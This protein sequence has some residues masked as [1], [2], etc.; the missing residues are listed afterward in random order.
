MDLLEMD[1]FEIVH[2][3]IGV[4]SQDEDLGIMFGQNGSFKNSL[5]EGSPTDENT[6]KRAVMREEVENMDVI[7]AEGNKAHLVAVDHVVKENN[8]DLLSGAATEPVKDREEISVST[9]PPNASRRGKKNA[10]SKAEKNSNSAICAKPMR[11]K[12]EKKP[13]SKKNQVN[14][15]TAAP[16]PIL[17]NDTSSST[18]SKQPRKE[19]ASE[20][21]GKKSVSLK[22]NSHVEKAA[23]PT[24]ANRASRAPPKNAPHGKVKEKRN[25]LRA[26][27]G[28]MDGNNAEVKKARVGKIKAVASD[29]EAKAVASAPDNVVKENREI[30]LSD[31]RVGS[32]IILRED[33]KEKFSGWTKN[34]NVFA[35]DPANRVGLLFCGSDIYHNSQSDCKFDDVRSHGDIT[36]R[37][38]LFHCAKTS[39]CK[40]EAIVIEKVNGTFIIRERRVRISG[41]CCVCSF[42][43][44]SFSMKR[45]RNLDE[46]FDQICNNKPVAPE[47][48]LLKNDRAICWKND[49]LRE[50]LVFSIK[51][52]KL[53]HRILD[54]AKRKYKAEKKLKA[55]IIGKD[56]SEPVMHALV[57]IGRYGNDYRLFF[58]VFTYNDEVKA[59]LRIGLE[60]GSPD[61]N[62]YEITVKGMELVLQLRPHFSLI[63]P[64]A[65]VK[66]KTTTVTSKTR[67]NYVLEKALERSMQ[68]L[69]V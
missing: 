41:V 53:F 35:N 32:L 21:R 30:F 58:S 48:A 3:D 16:T 40:A 37:L 54:D 1:S 43:K 44:T 33:T 69:T 50:V 64:A 18:P 39:R 4:M 28:D 49:R 5:F 59:V 31:V 11:G 52:C 47:Y 24:R 9:V 67:T 65:T 62:D 27:E 15:T 2:M 26:D 60:T 45:L 19:S 38:D 8:Q 61:R 36:G 66:S 23:S 22:N 63:T 10:P 57:Y 42:A 51:E 7:N 55:S 68:N 25:N 20:K 6:E 14:E 34:D 12:G 56:A 13:A 29:V 17:A 46:L